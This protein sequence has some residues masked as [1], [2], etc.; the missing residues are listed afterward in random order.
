MSVPG[1]PYAIPVPGERLMFTYQNWRGEVSERTV[2]TAFIR[3]GVNRWHPDPQWLLRGF[4]FDRSD[5]REF[6]M[7]D[8]TGVRGVSDAEL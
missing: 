6:A 7:K 5:F 8:M 1:R 2:L 3:F 4:D